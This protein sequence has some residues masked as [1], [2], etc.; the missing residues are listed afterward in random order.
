MLERL[1][2]IYF[3][4]RCVSIAMIKI[5]FDTARICL[6]T[7][8]WWKMICYSFSYYLLF[9]LLVL[10]LVSVFLK[11]EIMRFLSPKSIRNSFCFAHINTS[12]GHAAAFYS[13]CPTNAACVRFSAAKP[14][15]I[16]RH[17][18]A[19]IIGYTK[20]CLI[21]NWQIGDKNVA[22]IRRIW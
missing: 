18:C 6:F 22:R 10:E 12:V 3:W 16:M 21:K 15:T 17:I 20:D 1:R 8:E 5:H 2:D 19:W 4:C 13:Y 14:I 9:F 7:L 11:S